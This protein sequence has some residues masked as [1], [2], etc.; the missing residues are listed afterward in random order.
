[1]SNIRFHIENI[2]DTADAISF[3]SEDSEYPG[4]NVRDAYRTQVWRTTSGTSAVVTL[5]T[6]D[7]T[8][9]AR[10]LC[11]VNHN[12]TANG[13]IL[14]EVSDV[15]DFS[16]ILFSEEIEAHEPVFAWGEGKWGDNLWGGYL[17]PENIAKYTPDLV[18]VAYFPDA[19]YG[20]YWRITLTEPAESALEYI[21]IGRVI[22]GD[23]F[24]PEIQMQYGYTLEPVDDSEVT[25]SDGGQRFINRKP[26]RRKISMP[27]PRISKDNTHYDFFMLLYDIGKRQD[28]MT[29]IYPEGDPTGKFFHTI[30]GHITGS[31]PGI[32]IGRLYDK[33]TGNINILESL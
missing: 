2:V 7:K 3:S 23:Y 22:L 21:Q 28:F 16:N 14:V 8:G 10:A 29:V 20:R 13:T 26:K 24:E 15:S 12:L 25:Y 6:G 30:Y 18:R 27:F 4:L 9:Y 1:M 33:L 17:S 31:P 11:L 19:G 5:D 32:E